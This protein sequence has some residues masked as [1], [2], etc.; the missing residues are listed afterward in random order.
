MNRKLERREDQDERGQDH[1][2]YNQ[3]CQASRSLSIRLTSPPG[4][5]RKRM[6]GEKGIWKGDE[7]GVRMIIKVKKPESNPRGLDQKGPEEA[8]L[9]D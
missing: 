7:E 8:R 5:S 6:R 3:G 4:Q 9:Q 2:G 1:G